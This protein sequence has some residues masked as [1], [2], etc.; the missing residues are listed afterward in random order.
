[1]FD[2]EAP[3][4]TFIHTWVDHIAIISNAVIFHRKWTINTKTLD[5]LWEGRD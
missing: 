2:H 5:P 1:M 3:K 4:L